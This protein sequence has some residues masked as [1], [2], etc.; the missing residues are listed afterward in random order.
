MMDSTMQAPA[1]VGERLE[2]R[3]VFDAASIRAFATMSGDHNPIHHDE[4]HARRLGYAGLIACGP[5][6]TSLLMGL[7]SKFTQRHDALGLGFEFRFVKAIP[8]GIALTLEWT[9]AACRWKPSLAGHVVE[10]EGRA[11]DD[12]GI[13]YTTGR[14]AV[15]VRARSAGGGDPAH[16]LPEPATAAGGHG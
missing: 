16:R 15:L 4:A 14:G 11:R 3:V 8:E 13:V 5:Q 7:L 6:V 9:V 2:R 1:A 12:A 10:V